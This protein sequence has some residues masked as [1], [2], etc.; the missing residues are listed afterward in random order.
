[1]MFECVDAKGKLACKANFIIQHKKKYIYLLSIQVD[2]FVCVCF[3]YNLSPSQVTLRPHLSPHCLAYA[4]SNSSS[5]GSGCKL[6]PWFWILCGANAP[7][8]LCCLWAPSA[9]CGTPTLIRTQLS[10]KWIRH[11]TVFIW[12]DASAVYH[13]GRLWE[14]LM[15]IPTGVFA[16]TRERI[17]VD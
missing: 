1:M 9:V 17:S 12:T 13:L 15:N 3:L 4:Q 11:F 7:W 2:E 16:P 10:T 8:V 14:R 6:V 5:E